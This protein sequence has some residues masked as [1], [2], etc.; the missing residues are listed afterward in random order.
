MNCNNINMIIVVFEWIAVIILSIIAI[1]SR[2]KEETYEETYCEIS[3]D[4]NAAAKSLIRYREDFI[5]K[6]VT[7]VTTR[8]C[9]VNMNSFDVKMSN[10][11]IDKDTIQVSLNL[12]A[13][14]KMIFNID[15]HKKV[16]DCVY[17][18]RLD[19]NSI[20]DY[21]KAI[22]WKHDVVPYKNISKFCMKCG[23]IQYKKFNYENI[24]T[25]MYNDICEIAE[26]SMTHKDCTTASKLYLTEFI[27]HSL[28]DLYMKK[29]AKI[30]KEELYT[31]Y[32]TIMTYLLHNNFDDLCKSLDLTDACINELKEILTYADNIEV[33]TNETNDREQDIDS[34]SLQ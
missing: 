16:I 12:N 19:D 31:L 13:V 14:S 24:G 25:S 33:K 15:W 10:A 7:L 23:M 27:S 34:T 9:A 8:Y 21:N 28:Y 3:D 29:N 6:L 4:E 22:K 2:N 1:I 20:I 26:N 30:K 11:N 18:V 5:N 17:V 32:Y